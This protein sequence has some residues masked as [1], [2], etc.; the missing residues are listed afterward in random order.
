MKNLFNYKD[1]YDFVC[2]FHW[3]VCKDMENVHFEPSPDQ[4]PRKMK[5][6]FHPPPPPPPASGLTDAPQLQAEV[7]NLQ[8]EN[9]ILQEQLARQQA[10][11]HTVKVQLCTMRDDR[12]RFKKKVCCYGYF[13]YGF[14]QNFVLL[15]DGLRKTKY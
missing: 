14:P 13:G 9:G 5:P 1:N 10:D 2:L 8:L 4:S 12:D 6:M 3:Q 11:I 15:S 7:N